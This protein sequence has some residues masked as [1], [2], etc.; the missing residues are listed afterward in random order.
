M[1]VVGVLFALTWW[2]GVR[3]GMRLDRENAQRDAE[4]AEW[5]RTHPEE[6]PQP[7]PEATES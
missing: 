3:T 2:Y 6:R 5:E 4:Q 1:F 7:G